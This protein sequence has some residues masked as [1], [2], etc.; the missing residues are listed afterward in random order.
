MAKPRRVLLI[1]DDPDLAEMYG[2]QLRGVGYE[3]RTVDSAQKALDA[4]DR[5]AAELIILDMLL[6]GTN[7]L[8]ILHELRSYSDWREIPVIILSNVAAAE[9]GVKR[10]I[11]KQLGVSA[12]L[13]K[14]KIKSQ[15]LQVAVKVAL[16]HA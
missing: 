15:D 11:L 7:G 4:L 12:Y 6:P 1:E 3:L 13:E 5:Q 14:S 9:V 16:K 2:L 10:T 8:A